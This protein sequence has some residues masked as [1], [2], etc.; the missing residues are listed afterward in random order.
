MHVV[1]PKEQMEVISFD[2]PADSAEKPMSIARLLR[3]AVLGRVSHIDALVSQFLIRKTCGCCRL[4]AARSRSTGVLG[5]A[6][7][8]AS[9]PIGQRVGSEHHAIPDTDGFA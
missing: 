8:R 6:G 3:L 9:L 1:R 4:L 7:H 5:L 2:R